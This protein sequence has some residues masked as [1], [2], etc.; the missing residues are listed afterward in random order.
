MNFSSRRDFIRTSGLATLGAAGLVLRADAQPTPASG[1][2]GAYARYLQ[3]ERQGQAGQNPRNVD[4]KEG[5]EAQL[6]ALANDKRG[7]NLTL[8]GGKSS[9]ATE[10]NILGPFYRSGAPFRAKVTPPLEPGTVLV[11][12]GRVWGIDSR[13]PLPLTVLDIWQANAQGRYDNDDPSRPPDKDVFKYRTRLVT[14]ETGYYE[15]ETIHPAAYKIGP[16]AWRPSHI[17]YLVRAVGYKTLVT[18]LYFSGD[19]YNK[20]DEFIKKS[21]IIDVREQKA[22]GGSYETGT[23]DI[24]LEP[25]TGGKGEFAK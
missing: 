21:L 10:D 22:S 18:Q 24:V 1:R 16:D 13:K 19:K 9:A 3:A 20:T 6:K 8:A 11:I 17:H 7:D 14:D 25:A 15:F 23:F 12:S 4:P 2:L 5:R